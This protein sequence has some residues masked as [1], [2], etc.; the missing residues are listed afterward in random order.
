MEILESNFSKIQKFWEEVLRSNI[1][2]G[3]KTILLET[4]AW[5][6]KF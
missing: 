3:P 5:I 6:E 1:W 4:E 2:D